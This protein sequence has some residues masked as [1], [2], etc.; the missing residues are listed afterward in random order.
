MLALLARLFDNLGTVIPYEDLCL[1][2]G[3]KSANWAATHVLRQ[4]IASLTGRVLPDVDARSIV[5]AARSI[6]ARGFQKSKARARRS[7]QA[8][9]FAL[10]LD[11]VNPLP[12]IKFCR[13]QKLCS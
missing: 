5:A 11:A 4:Y 1:L 2:I 13:P 10:D 7:R 3:H 6:T 12:T 8:C 9:W